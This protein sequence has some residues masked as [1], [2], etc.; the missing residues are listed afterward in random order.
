MFQHFTNN[1]PCRVSTI[2]I[3]I[4]PDPNQL[5]HCQAIDHPSASAFT[6]AIDH[7]NSTLYPHEIRSHLSPSTLTSSGPSQAC[8]SLGRTRTR[9][10]DAFGAPAACEASEP[11]VEGNPVE[12]P[13]LL[14]YMYMYSCT[15]VHACCLYH[16]TT[17]S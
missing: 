2:N 8:L 12:P 5:I 7:H 16:G 9:T 6:P 1:L 10:H 15:M 14:Y 3:N 17:I 11:H 13:P 4:C